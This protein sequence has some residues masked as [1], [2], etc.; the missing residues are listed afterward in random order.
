MVIPGFSEALQ[1]MRVG[2]VWEIYIPA[3]LGYGERVNPQ[4]GIKPNS[5]LIFEIHLVGI[6]EKLE[7]LP[8]AEPNFLR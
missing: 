8:G 6:T 5:A 3:N 2:S 4:S 1:L 7:I